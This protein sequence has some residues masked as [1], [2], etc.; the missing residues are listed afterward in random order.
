[1]G[2]KLKNENC[3]TFFLKL[4]QATPFKS[5]EPLAHQ[6]FFIHLKHFCQ[7]FIFQNARKLV[8]IMITKR[9]IS[10]T[11]TSYTIYITKQA[12]KYEGNGLKFV[13]S[14]THLL[15]FHH[16]KHTYTHTHRTYITP[17]NSTQKLNK[18]RILNVQQQLNQQPYRKLQ[19][20]PAAQYK[21]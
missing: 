1:M 7:F 17:H 10:T 6:S 12:V 16:S 21:Q 19:Q 2:N 20:Q 5:D 15:F 3:L 11:Y 9:H 8:F 18:Y 4:I 14:R 13:T